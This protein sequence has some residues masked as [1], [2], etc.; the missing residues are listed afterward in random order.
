M[1][2]LKRNSTP[3]LEIHIISCIIEA[4]TVHDEFLPIEFQSLTV[5]MSHSNGWLIIFKCGIFAQT[6]TLHIPTFTTDHLFQRGCA[7]SW[8]V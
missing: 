7:S 6:Q 2:S 3:F 1:D 8:A 5:S 4:Q